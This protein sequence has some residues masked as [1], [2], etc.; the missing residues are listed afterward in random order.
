M[1]VV[2]FPEAGNF[3]IIDANQA[4][5]NIPTVVIAATPSTSTDLGSAVVPYFPLTG[6]AADV[7]TAVNQLSSLGIAGTPASRSNYPIYTPNAQD[8]G[9]LATYNNQST[10]NEGESVTYYVPYRL[11]WSGDYDAIVEVV[12]RLAQPIPVP[13][14]ETTELSS[15]SVQPGATNSSSGLVSTSAINSP[16]ATGVTAPDNGTKEDGGSKPGADGSSNDDDTKLLGASVGGTFGG[17]VFGVV[18]TFLV[19]WCLRRR[20]NRPNA[21]RTLRMEGSDRVAKHETSP[22][23]NDTQVSDAPTSITGWQKHLPQEKDEKTIS[24]TIK[25]IFD[26]V[27]MY[28]EDYYDG[29]PRKID[30]SAIAVL[31]RVS[32]AGLTNMLTTSS[33]C[34]PVLEAILIGWIVHRISLR[35]DA[36]DSFLPFEYT[37]IPEQ[38]GWHMESDDDDSG[39]V[40]ETKKGELN[41]LKDHRYK[42]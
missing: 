6:K 12:S 16:Q 35:S 20:R 2:S 38:N 32:T 11:P 34:I 40:R 5:G 29:K 1:V 18:G 27:Q 3:T 15:P 31:G 37:K 14:Q 9:K 4:S 24:R 13:S 30:H 21:K 28:T 25:A 23:S 42:H 7:F 36:G 19:L 39:H 8:G 22:T 10:G 33:N 26:Q 41:L 17:I